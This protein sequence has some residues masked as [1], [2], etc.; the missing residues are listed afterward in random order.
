[1]RCPDG[2]VRWPGLTRLEADALAGVISPGDPAPDD[3]LVQIALDAVLTDGAGPY[4]LDAAGLLVLVVGRHPAGAGVHVAMGQPG[5]DRA[6]IGA[7]AQAGA[8]GRWR[9]IARADVPLAAR[10]ATLDALAE[11][12]DTA[13]LEAWAARA[14]SSGIP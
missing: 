1:V 9:W 7:V 13:A 10:I 12:G 2:A 14:K 11:A 5:L 8:G 4:L 3:V 6:R